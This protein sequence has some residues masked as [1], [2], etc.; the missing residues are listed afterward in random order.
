MGG[1][2]LLTTGV[3]SSAIVL[4]IHLIDKFVKGSDLMRRPRKEE[5]QDIHRRLGVLE[6]TMK[7]MLEGAEYDQL[8]KRVQRLEIGARERG[9]AG[10]ERRGIG[11]D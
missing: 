3:A 11:H 4:A 8:A 1:V 10:I 7:D 2:D 5:D 9:W 6:R